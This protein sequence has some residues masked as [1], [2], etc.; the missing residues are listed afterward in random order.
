MQPR[1][2]A[3]RNCQSLGL[4]LALTGE[5]F[6]TYGTKYLHSKK[7]ELS[8]KRRPFY[9]TVAGRRGSLETD[10]LIIV[11]NGKTKRHHEGYICVPICETN[12]SPRVR[13]LNDN[14]Q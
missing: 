13:L 7:F 6:T 14:H 5:V 3:Y 12:E 10:S 1:H 8:S 2:G 4:W 11:G 9:D